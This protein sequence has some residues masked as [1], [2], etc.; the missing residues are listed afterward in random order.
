MEIEIKVKIES[1]EKLTALLSEEGVLKYTDKQID[2]YYVPSHRNFMELDPVEEWLRLRDSNG[3]YSFNY[4]KWIYNSEGKSNHCDEYETKIE[5]IEEMRKILT[6]VD[7]KPLVIVDKNRIAWDYQDYEI[8]FDKVE[9][10]GDFIEIEYKGNN[11]DSDPE[12]VTN[13]MMEFLESLD[14]GKIERNYKG[15]PY[16]ALEQKGLI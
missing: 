16:L 10:L 4:K 12:V 13:Q 2:E 8:S 14:C 6:A 1:S 15:Y 9:G 11:G 5:N 3:V 7:F